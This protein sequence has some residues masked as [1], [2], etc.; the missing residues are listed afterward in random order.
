[1]NDKHYDITVSEKEGAILAYEANEITEHQL[2]QAALIS[3]LEEKE[4]EQR[5]HNAK[6][7]SYFN[8]SHYLDRTAHDAIKN[9]DDQEAYAEMR[10]KTFLKTIFNI[11]KLSGFYIENR[12]EL[13]DLKTGK[14]WR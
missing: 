9:I 6:G 14:T 11:C 2:K 4:Q 10:Y 5:K 12:L 3:A 7:N 1:M 13:K 8:G